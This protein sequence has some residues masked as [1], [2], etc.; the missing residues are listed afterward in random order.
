MTAGVINTSTN[1]RSVFFSD[2]T[3]HS[4]HFLVTQLYPATELVF[5]L[6]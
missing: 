4:I 3:E 1:L 6:H 2:G 5:G